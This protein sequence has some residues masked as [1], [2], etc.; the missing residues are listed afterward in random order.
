MSEF[1]VVNDGGE[2]GY[3]STDHGFRKILAGDVETVRERLIYALEKLDYRLLNER[4][5][6][7]RPGRP[8]SSCSFDIL[9]CIKSL[10]ITL[11]PFNQT[12]TLVAF[13]Y[14]ILNPFVTKGDQQTLEREAE[15]LIAL[16]AASPAA[17]ICASCGT[18]N[19]SDSRF[20][21]AC[22]TPNSAGEPAEL[23]ILRLT[24][25]ARVA[26]QSIT[27]AIIAAF[28]VAAISLSLI[29]FKG[30]GL[31]FLIIGEIFAFAWLSYGMW[32]LHHTLNPKEDARPLRTRAQI[33]QTIP[34]RQIGLLS[35][36]APQASVT[37]GTTE[38]LAT[39]E[40]ERAAV[41]LKPQKVD[42]AEIQG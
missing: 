8:I 11:K 12:S 35:Q 40:R 38:L 29:Y 7:A 37:E 3:E 24:A 19:S 17:T 25:G 31:T 30:K 21:R 13:N 20:C 14:E 9:D 15:A 4:P 10:S 33:P 27:G 42:T 34:T 32:Y 23:E 36:P 2:G 5:L 28:V 6:V 39:P 41:P 18:N 22:G 26:H 1:I 16:A